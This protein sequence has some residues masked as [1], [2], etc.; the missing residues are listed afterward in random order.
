MG[1]FENKV[2]DLLAGLA[3]SFQLLLPATFLVVGLALLLIPSAMTDNTFVFVAMGIAV[4]T[5]YYMLY[6]FNAAIMNFF[7]GDLMPNWAPIRALRDYQ[8]GDGS[9]IRDTG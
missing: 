3:S 7:K 4:L 5:V 2:A 6:A 8:I 9:L 1:I